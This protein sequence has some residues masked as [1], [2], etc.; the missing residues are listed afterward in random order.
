MQKSESPDHPFRAYHQ[1]RK[2]TA[3]WRALAFA[4]ALAA[5]VALTSGIQ[6]ARTPLASAATAGHSPSAG[7][8]ATTMIPATTAFPQ[9]VEV[10]AT[11]VAPGPQLVSPPSTGHHGW[12]IVIDATGYQTEID[13]CL[14][15][16]MQLGAVAPI[17]GAH[18]YCGGSIVLDMRAGDTVVL[19]GMGLDGTYVVTAG[20][21]AHA[22]DSAAIAT[23]QLA[24]DVILQ[25]CY[26]HSN[27]RERLIALTK[28]SAPAA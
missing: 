15:V 10:S 25:T 2:R 6:G 23:A 1:A 11:L 3:I 7:A 20:R 28:L 18:N 21:D 14:W 8:T 16:R 12:S 9:P 19:S 5:A 26:W 24:A 13:R 22:G 17:V 4:A 27:G